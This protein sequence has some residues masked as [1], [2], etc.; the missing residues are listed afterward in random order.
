MTSFLKKK[1]VSQSFD[2]KEL[3]CFVWH[4]QQSQWQAAAERG[5]SEAMP[6]IFNAN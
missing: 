5:R 3:G 6:R 1:N 2:L 4:K